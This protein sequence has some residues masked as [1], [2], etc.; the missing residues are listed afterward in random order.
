MHSKRWTMHKIVYEIAKAGAMTGFVAR[1]EDLGSVSGAIFTPNAD[2]YADEEQIALAAYDRGPVIGIARAGFV[3]PGEKKPDIYFEDLHGGFP[4]CAFAY[5]FGALDT[6]LITAQLDDATGEEDIQGDPFFAR[7]PDYFRTD[8]R[9]RKVSQGFLKSCA[10][11]LKAG[12]TSDIDGPARV[13]VVTY[14]FD[15]D[16]VRVVVINDDRFHY[17]KPVIL[18]KKPIHYVN[19][20]SR[21][22]V[23]P[24]KLVNQ[25]SDGLYYAFVAKVPP[26]GLSIF[27]LTFEK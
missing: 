25:A 20:V 21:Y 24:P 11:L 13:P 7:D 10:A 3:L 15:D 4:F 6:S 27:D 17:I 14:T 16:R 19:P 22:P 2:L 9:Y 8:L 18:S 12:N 5:N 23:L 26:A 1:T